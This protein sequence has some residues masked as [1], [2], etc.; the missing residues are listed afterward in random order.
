MSIYLPK[1]LEPYRNRIAAWSDE[2]DSSNLIFIDYRA[3]WK[4]STDP[5]GIQRFSLRY[6]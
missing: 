6:P 1:S 3:G 4:S 5:V 2:R